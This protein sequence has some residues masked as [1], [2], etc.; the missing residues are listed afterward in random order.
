[1]AHFSITRESQGGFA[2]ERRSLEAEQ[3]LQLKAE[4]LFHLA[5]RTESR[6]LAQAAD[7]YRQL[8]G[9]ALQE[10]A[11][12]RLQALNGEGS[13]GDQVEIHLRNFSR[14]ATDP[15]MLFAMGTAGA[16]FKVTRLATL[17][18]LISGPASVLTRGWG[19]RA[20][21]STVAF[22]VEAPAFP[23]AGRLAHSALGQ[24]Q[25]WSPRA[26]GRDFL[27]SALV[28]GGMKLGGLAS[29][30]MASA[31]HGSSGLSAFA[32]GAFRQSGMLGGILLGH[33]FEELAGLRQSKSTAAA[34]TEA[35]AMLLQFN[36]A[37][38]LNQAAWGERFGRWEQRVELQTREVERIFPNSGWG[39]RFF[40]M[41]ALAMAAAGDKGSKPPNEIHGPQILMMKGE[42]RE[43]APRSLPPLVEVSFLQL[44]NPNMAVAESYL[45]HLEFLLLQNGPG[46][47]PREYVN[48]YSRLHAEA[49]SLPPALSRKAT[50]A[51]SETLAV[52]KLDQTG[53]QL[54]FKHLIH[55]ERFA[56]YSLGDSMTAWLR[57]P[58]LQP[59]HRRRLLQ[60]AADIFEKRPSP[61]SE[62]ALMMLTCGWHRFQGDGRS[63]RR[64]L[65]GAIRFLNEHEAWFHGRF[66]GLE[67]AKTALLDPNL[68]DRNRDWIL[69]QMQSAL[70]SVQLGSPQRVRVLQT[71]ED[72]VQ[73]SD[74]T[75]EQRE[76]FEGRL[77][78][79]RSELLYFIEKSAKENLLHHYAELAYLLTQDHVPTLQKRKFANDLLRAF[80]SAAP[81]S[82]AYSA[83]FSD[84]M[85]YLGEPS[86]EPEF[87][88][89]FTMQLLKV[90]N[91]SLEMETKVL[92][93]QVHRMNQEFIASRINSLPE[94]ERIGLA[95]HLIDELGRRDSRSE[96]ASELI[97]T[98]ASMLNP[99]DDLRRRLSFA[100]E[101]SHNPLARE[102]AQFIL[103][104][105]QSL[106]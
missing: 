22:A 47:R 26:L 14:E 7:I 11:A 25:D 21:A 23:L 52:A 51:L 83:M 89:T 78:I 75:A 41:P 60:L 9:T 27:S 80:F 48:L 3:D 50:D 101:N 32:S 97:S 40:G 79:F 62:E 73:R 99:T 66:N 36:V 95:N 42:S 12:R 86:L 35:F 106:N 96:R 76:I 72:L 49:R 91:D 39:E 15:T 94:E 17:S 38:R 102:V 81:D 82:V 2:A 55:S 31:L 24:S 105:W 71:L 34:L 69:A 90:L 4:G 28:L 1:M 98:L 85:K 61:S 46:L 45:A 56:A 84:A 87:R 59:R 18:R 29:S 43:T 70:H 67:F 104:Q 54:L 44:R 77:P 53:P 103:E 5:R 92:A 57:N 10:R 68:S 64:A 30:S 37:G 8:A 93:P 33:R 13:F 58:T 100:A 74:L 88:Q 63:F 65:N 19:A 16:L 6:D 20:L